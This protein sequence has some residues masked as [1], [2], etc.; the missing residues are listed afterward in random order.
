MVEDQ[1]MARGIR[2]PRVLQAFANVPR[3]RFVEEGL[4]PKAYGDHALPIGHGQTISQPYMVAL[5]SEALALD[6]S[7]KV[8]EIGTGSGY[9]AAILAELADRV[10]T[11]ERMGAL[12]TGAKAILDGLGYQNVILRVADGS[13]GWKEFAPFDRIIVTAGA[14]DVP[15]SLLDQLR[16]NGL[17]VILIG[18]RSSQ[19]LI[20]VYREPGG[21]RVEEICLCAFVPLVGREGWADAERYPGGET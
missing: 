15:R 14:P 9:Q 4:W 11:V 21:D 10:F 13:I 2:D 18:D 19:R 7:E 3:H 8:L 6:G 5:M 1:L 17:F 20:R 12:A 16:A